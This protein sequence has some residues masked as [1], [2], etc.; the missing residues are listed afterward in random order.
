[1][2]IFGSLLIFLVFTLG[3]QVFGGQSSLSIQALSTRAYD[4]GQVVVERVLERNRS[5]TRSLV[6]W[7]SDSTTQY[8]FMDIP[9]GRGPFATVIMIHGHVNPATYQTL[10]YT[11]RYADALARVGYV[12]IHPNL[13]GH[14][15][16]GGDRKSV[17]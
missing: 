8:G 9:K 6:H 15:L 11:T 5:F 12:V 14:G 4:G 13:R 2:K 10:A 3:L 17:V 16:S 1:M 7:Q